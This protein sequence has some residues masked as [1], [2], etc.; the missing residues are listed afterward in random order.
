MNRMDISMKTGESTLDHNRRYIPGGI[1]S[2]NRT[3]DPAITFTKAQGAYLWDSAGKR[4]IDYHA[5]FAPYFLG[6]NFAPINEAAAA[7]LTS[8]DSLFGAG[9]SIAEG[10][11]AELICENVPAAEKVTFLNTGSEAT[12]LA[13]RIGRAVT[14]R[15]HIIAMQG[16]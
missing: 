12:S 4:Y 13:I 14:R 3:I 16:G 7:A 15:Q 8:G 6:H 10:R 1:S 11:L 9:P 5:G 2:V